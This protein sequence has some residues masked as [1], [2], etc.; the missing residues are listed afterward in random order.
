MAY[1]YNASTLT[2]ILIG[3]FALSLFSGMLGLGAA[4]ATIPYL[5]IFMAD[6]VHEVHQLLCYLMVL[7]L[8]LALSAS[9][10][11]VLSSGVIPYY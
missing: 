8:C 6:I 3:V 2:A 10:G 1:D 4:F 9:L 5:S 11:V 7:Q